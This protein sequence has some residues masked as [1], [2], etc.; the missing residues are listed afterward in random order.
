VVC[1]YDDPASRSY[2]GRILVTADTPLTRAPSWWASVLPE[3]AS[4][5][6]LTA[7]TKERMF[8]GGGLQLGEYHIGPRR[9]GLLHLVPS[10][11]VGWPCGCVVSVPVSAATPTRKVVDRFAAVRERAK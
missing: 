11:P 6:I 9:S 7:T 8:A 2:P 5:M 1:E 10:T 4:R 3:S